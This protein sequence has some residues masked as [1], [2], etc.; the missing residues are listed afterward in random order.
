MYGPWERTATGVEHKV[1]IKGTLETFNLR[2]LLQMLS[3]NQKDGTLVLETERGPRTVHIEDGRAAFVSGDRHA[4]RA[5]GRVCRRRGLV[6]DDR[7]ERAE[8]ITE[9]TGRF[10]GEVLTELGAIEGDRFE[11]A[12]S[13]AVA[14]SLFDLQLSSIQRFEFVEG[15]TLTPDGTSGSPIEPRIVVDGLLLELTRKIDQWGVLTESVPSLHEIFEGTG[16]EVD[17][18]GQEELDVAQADRVVPRIDGFHTL[19][20]VSETSDVDRYTVLQVSVALLQGGAIRPVPS[21]DLVARAEDVLAKGEAASALPLLRR[22]LER[23]DAPPSARVRL[24]DALEATGDAL[25][26]AAELDTF[27]ALADESQAVEVF[28]ALQRALSLRDGDPATAARVCDHYLRH[29]PWLRAKRT[30]GLAALRTLIHGASNAGRPLD[31]AQRLACFVQNNDAPSEELM[32]LADLYTAGGERGEAA[33]ALFRRAEDLLALQRVAAARDLLRRT[34]ELD[35]SRSDARRR[36]QELEGEARRRRRQKRVIVL[37]VLLTLLVVGGG[38]AWWMLNRESSRTIRESRESAESALREAE[39]KVTSLVAAFRTAVT[40][41]EKS[42]TIPAS[43]PV[44]V[45]TLME[46]VKARSD[47]LRAPLGAYAAELERSAGRRSESN[48]QIVRGLDQR[49]QNLLGRAQGAVT[50]IRKRAE[51]LLQEGERANKAGIFLEARQLLVAARNLGFEDATVRERAL[52][53]LTHIDAYSK[54]CEAAIEEIATFRRAGDFEGAAKRAFAALQELQDSD[55]TAQMRI[56]LTITSTPAGAEVLLGGKPTGKTTPCEIDYAPFGDTTVA[57]RLPGRTNHKFRLPDYALVQRSPDTL[58]TWSPRLAADLP[59]GWR[60]RIEHGKE[61]RMSAIWATGDV[62]VVLY[63]DGVTA[64]PVDARAGVLGPALTNRLSNPLRRGGT[65]AG[66]TEWRILG[67]R[68]LR[69]KTSSSETWEVQCIGRLERAPVLVDGVLLAVDEAGT[70]YAYQVDTGTE[71]W[72]KA[73]GAP[74]SQPP[75]PSRLGVI[76]ATLSGGAL[77]FD[78]QRGDSRTLA[79]A[80]RG[81]TLALPFGDGALLVG[82]GTGGLKRFSGDGIVEVLGDAHP[83]G[84]RDA[85]VSYD[86]VAWVDAD[87]VRWMATGTQEPVAVPALGKNVVM[88]TGAPGALYGLGSDNMLRSADPGKPAVT[89]WSTPLGGPAMTQ[90]LVLGDALFILVDGN[91]VAVER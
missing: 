51:A 48:D 34:L 4:S 52:V 6:P 86:G 39:E 47:E 50:E 84:E 11:D 73:L 43:L 14:E 89:L 66:G 21:E 90:P 82:S 23:G 81:L 26:A 67:Y 59:P 54:R 22:A 79:P 19:D 83:T 65:F 20:Q 8:Q 35:P 5:L 30:E 88:L 10:L 46:G 85:F 12:Y 77:A 53:L 37:L 29:R 38:G 28:D 15:K 64:R 33:S 45:K 76:V 58:K 72:R 49:R 61:P 87:G 63:D 9:R 44:A 18:A 71:L 40:E 75:Y 70:L 62:P 16:I 13:E 42:P 7:M 69:V 56:P 27:S 32:V 68:T 1:S 91:L 60:W 36:L 57:L 31:A 3:F 78:P 25:A 2:E 80:G 74:P 41:A 55:L 17:L 24:A